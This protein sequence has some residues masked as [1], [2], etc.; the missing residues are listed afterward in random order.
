MPVPAT[1]QRLEP[2]IL[3][4][5]SQSPLLIEAASA[6]F[7][8]DALG[9]VANHIAEHRDH[10][11]ALD[12][13][14]SDDDFWPTDEDDWMAY[15]RPYNVKGGVLTI[16]ISGV[17]LNKFSYTIPGWATGYDYIGRAIDRGMADSNVRHIALAVHSPGGEVA[18]CFELSDKIEGLRGQKPITAFSWDMAY[19]AAYALASAANELVVTRSGGTGS[20]GVV[21]MHVDYSEAMKKWG[22][23]VTFIYAGKYKV[24]GNGYEPLADEARD[25]IQ[26]RIDRLYG[27]FVETVARNR[28]MDQDA[29]R[30]TEAM[31]YDA[32][33]SVEIGFADRIGSPEDEIAA[34]MSAQPN[35][36]ENV[37]MAQTPT[38]PVADNSAAIAA[39]T[40][41]GR[42]EGAA[43]ERARI[44]AVMESPAAAD[45]PSTAR[46]MALGDKFA[47]LDAET[48]VSLLADLPKESAKAEEPKGEKP[49]ATGGT[50]FDRAMSQTENPG[51]GAEAQ[52]EEQ[53]SE[54][55]GILTASRLTTGRTAAKAA[56]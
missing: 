36:T 48:I 53:V 13:R 11:V 46:T 54:A 21:T 19:S 34:M 16:N 18:G 44:R 51:I 8:R 26:A 3:S 7:V 38:D 49:K 42:A 12:A 14:M 24:E 32:A 37:S 43:A 30:K 9:Y 52:T 50:P 41:T 10:V 39:A 2:P 17:L 4:Q 31:C 40:A 5:V 15:Y 25:R 35:H 45:R 27:V 28:G 55:Q 47:A 20:V 56:R 29:V 6:D 1:Q 33:D 23:K 22:V